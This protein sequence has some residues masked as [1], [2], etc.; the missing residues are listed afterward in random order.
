MLFAIA[1]KAE[2]EMFWHYLADQTACCHTSCLTRHADDETDERCHLKAQHLLTSGTKTRCSQLQGCFF[3]SFFFGS[4]LEK[5]SE[6]PHIA[7][8]FWMGLFAHCVTR[9]TSEVY[10]QNLCANDVACLEQLVQ[11]ELTNTNTHTHTNTS[12]HSHW[13]FISFHHFPYSF[14]LHSG[15]SGLSPIMWLGLFRHK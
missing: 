5:V 15:L 14:M 11:S 9:R 7:S 3:F 6:E 1:F 2:W 13:F 10:F 12:T 4:T 8:C